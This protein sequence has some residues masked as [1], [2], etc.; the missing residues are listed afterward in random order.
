MSFLK[1]S[2]MT[3]NSLRSLIEQNESFLI[4]SHLSLDGDCVGSQL[5]FYWYLISLGKKAVIYNHD[6][7]PPK[8]MFLR[9][10]DAMRAN[11]PE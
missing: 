4:S 6:P 9:D 1:K 8:F 7:V 5:A 11:M 2:A 10:A 3:W